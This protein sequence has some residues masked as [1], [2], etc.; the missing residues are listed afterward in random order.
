[1]WQ[2]VFVPGHLVLD[3]RCRDLEV[4][5]EIAV[6]VVLNVEESIVPLPYWCSS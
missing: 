3:V 6:R 4:A 5:V 2:S 1:M